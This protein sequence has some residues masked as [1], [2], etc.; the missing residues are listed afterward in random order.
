[1]HWRPRNKNQNKNLQKYRW[2]YKFKTWNESNIW[3]KYGKKE[4]KSPRLEQLNTE[5]AYNFGIVKTYKNIGGR[6]P[7][8]LVLL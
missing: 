3:K 4:Y 5:R 6:S 7:R 2:K 1:M 8:S